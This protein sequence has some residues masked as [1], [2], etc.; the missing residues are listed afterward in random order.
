MSYN[1][2]YAAWSAYVDYCR[3]NGYRPAHVSEHLSDVDPEYVV[4]MNIKARL[5]KYCVFTGNICLDRIN[6]D[7]SVFDD[8][9]TAWYDHCTENK[10][11]HVKPVASDFSEDSRYIYLI[12]DNGYL[13]RYNIETGKIT[14]ELNRR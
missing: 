8:A 9:L 3:K 4:L 1:L 2:Y 5:A 6:A 10:L 12:G 14:S 7:I 11:A 13:A